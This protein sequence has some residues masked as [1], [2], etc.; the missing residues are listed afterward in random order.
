M[1]YQFRR[2]IAK[3]DKQ[4]AVIAHWLTTYIRP[5]RKTNFVHKPGN[6]EVQTGT[7]L[8]I[9]HTHFYLSLGGGRG[10]LRVLY[11]SSTGYTYFLVGLQS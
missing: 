7:L 10:C 5:S 1:F 4:C 6:L 8:Q 2:L 11:L 9:S 3:R